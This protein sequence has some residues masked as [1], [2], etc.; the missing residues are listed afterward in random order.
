[1]SERASE[2]VSQSVCDL[3]KTSLRLSAWAIEKEA[4]AS[5]LQA[6]IKE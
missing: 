5:K 3:T 6:C 2:R 4:L 1:V